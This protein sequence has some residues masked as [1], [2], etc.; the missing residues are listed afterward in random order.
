MKKFSLRSS[1][2]T[3]KRKAVPAVMCASLT[4]MTAVTAFAEEPIDADLAVTPEMLQPILTGV[5]ANVKVILP[6]AI[7]IFIILFGPQLAMK[8]IKKF[9]KP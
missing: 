5:S 6:V 4:A 9:A 1:F 2:E 8:I 7:G 3:L